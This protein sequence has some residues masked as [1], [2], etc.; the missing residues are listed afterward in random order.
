M[1]A[2]EL[3]CWWNINIRATF[4]HGCAEDGLTPGLIIVTAAAFR[5]V[6]VIPASVC[7]MRLLLS[8]W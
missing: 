2:E 6:G 8:L 1:W 3:A 7:L 4:A 5:Y